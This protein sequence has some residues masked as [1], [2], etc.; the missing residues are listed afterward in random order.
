LESSLLRHLMVFQFNYLWLKPDDPESFPD[1]L[2]DVLGDGY[3]TALPTRASA[4]QS[5][6]DDASRLRKQM[7]ADRLRDIEHLEE[8]NDPFDSFDSVPRQA[9]KYSDETLVKA[10][11]YCRLPVSQLFILESVPKVAFL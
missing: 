6:L 1:G 9:A 7:R 11:D 10:R 3:L 2:I 5:G 8:T 4:S